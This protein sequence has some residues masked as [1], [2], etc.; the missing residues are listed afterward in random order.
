M[1]VNFDDYR[2]AR[3][4]GDGLPID[5]AS[6]AHRILSYLAAHPDLGFKPAEIREHVDVPAGSVNPTL[7]RLE[8]RGLV[9][10]ESPYWS[11]G[12]DDR[13]AALDGTIASMRAFE[14]RHGD[15]DFEGWHE[16]D[17]DPR[18]QRQGPDDHER[19]VGHTDSE[20]EPHDTGSPSGDE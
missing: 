5:P 3:D 20:R 6:N 19:R 9:E 13:L 12:D 17:V 1:P 4:D 16:S 15:D 10:H 11:A 8:E 2:E 14:D 7:A 18:E